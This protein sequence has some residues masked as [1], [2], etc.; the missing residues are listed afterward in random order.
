MITNIRLRRQWIAVDSI[1]LT[2]D[3]FIECMVGDAGIVFRFKSAI[4]YFGGIEDFETVIRLAN[5]SQVGI[6]TRDADLYRRFV[7]FGRRK[8]KVGKKT[9]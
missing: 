8:G 5:P 2:E 4:P 3:G 6:A 9:A 1:E 7:E